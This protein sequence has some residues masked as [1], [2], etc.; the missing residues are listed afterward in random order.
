MIAGDVTTDARCR[1]SIIDS[2]VLVRDFIDFLKCITTKVMIFINQMSRKLLSSNRQAVADC[3]MQSDRREFERL[4]VVHSGRI[5]S[6]TGQFPQ[7]AFFFA[8]DLP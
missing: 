4:V 6:D 8:D 7:A 2:R 1:G 5:D 3:I